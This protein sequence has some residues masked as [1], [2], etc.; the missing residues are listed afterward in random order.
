MSDT[1]AQFAVL[2]QT[3]DPAVVDAISQLI[4]KGHD[5]ELNRI[6]LLDFAARTGLDEEKVISAFLHSARLGLFDLSWNVLCPGCGGVL[7]AHNTLKSLRHDDYNCA[8]CAQGY[9]ASVDDRVEVSFTVSPRV[10]RITAHDPNTLPIWEY[11]RQMFWSSGMDL[12]DES[13]AR[14]IDEVSLEAIELPAGEKAV[15]SLQLPNQFVIVVEPVTHAAHFLN[16]P[17]EPTPDRQPISIGF[18]KPQA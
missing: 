2:K 12:N 4:E 16:L 9:E 17:G 6:N 3:A 11:T 18:N 10:R 15:L 7:G 14:L 8:L 5:R 1:Q 13:I